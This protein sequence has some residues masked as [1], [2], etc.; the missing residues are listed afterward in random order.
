MNIHNL[1][2]RAACT[3][4]L[5]ACATTAALAKDSGFYF[6]LGVGQSSFDVE[7]E[8]SGFLVVTNSIELDDD[9]VAIAMSL[10]YRANPYVGL[11]LSYNDLGDIDLSE[12]GRIQTFAPTQTGT[13]VVDVS[14]G[15]RGVSLAI[16]GT[17][18]LQKFELF[19]K[20]GAIRTEIRGEGR[21]YGI[22]GTF[23]TFV[24]SASEDTTEALVGVGAGYTAGDSLFL[25]L[26]WVRIPNLGDKMDFEEADTDVISAGFQY[27][28]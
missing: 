12:T 10:G 13:G 18:P 25:K 7:R 28:F 21:G 11:E 14:I 22:G 23:S 17:L 9:D 19:G 27:R 2:C 15:V 5:S 3:L 20:L 16:V 24:A 26:E 4:A 6:G 8:P 1:L